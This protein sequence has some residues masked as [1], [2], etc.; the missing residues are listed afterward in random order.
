MECIISSAEWNSI[1]H[2]DEPSF[3]YVLLDHPSDVGI[4]AFGKTWLASE[5]AALALMSVI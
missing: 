3:G 1:P 2:N 4:E 5:Q